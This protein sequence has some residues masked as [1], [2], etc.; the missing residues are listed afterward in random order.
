MERFGKLDFLIC[1]AFPPIPA[2]RLETNTLARIQGYLRQSTDLVLV[3]LCVFLPLLNENRGCAVII[4][5]SAVEKPV[6]EW[7]HY[8]AAKSAI[9]SFGV[10]APLQYPNVGALIVR[11][12]RLLTD[13]TNTPMGRQDAMPPLVFARQ[14]TEKLQFP[15]VAGTAEI[16]RGSEKEV[17]HNQLQ[18]CA[19]S[20]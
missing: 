12:E 6:R 1:N 11:P 3:P 20:Q 18:S 17:A 7:P 14:I 15:P 9:E 2:L 19:L 10:V 16:F 5:S 8:V 4:S 13:M